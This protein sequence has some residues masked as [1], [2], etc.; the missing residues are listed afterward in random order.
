MF[1]LSDF[2]DTMATKNVDSNA[3]TMVIT[4]KRTSSGYNPRF[5]SQSN[6]PASNFNS[7]SIKGITSGSVRPTM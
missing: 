3:A 6:A 7:N 2:E 4:E 5:E 1:N